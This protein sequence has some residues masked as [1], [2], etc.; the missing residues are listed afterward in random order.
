MKYRHSVWSAISIYFHFMIFFKFSWVYMKYCL[1]EFIVKSKNN[2]KISGPWKDHLGVTLW[3]TLWGLPWDGPGG[4]DLGLPYKWPFGDRPRTSPRGL[5]WGNPWRV[6][7]PSFLFGMSNRTSFIHVCLP[8]FVKN[9][10][11]LGLETDS[12]YSFFHKNSIIKKQVL[13]PIISKF[14]I[15]NR[16]KKLN[17]SII[18]CFSCIFNCFSSFTKF[19]GGLFCFARF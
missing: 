16:N 19:S 2:L 7:L 18:T 9:K 1:C 12:N 11:I 8:V 13:N 15:K 5:F 10:C 4:T 14:R 17:Q 6:H 3:T